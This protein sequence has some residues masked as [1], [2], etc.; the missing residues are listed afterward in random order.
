MTISGTAFFSSNSQDYILS[1]SA[2]G[3]QASLSDLAVTVIDSK[4]LSLSGVDLRGCSG[5]LS[6]VLQYAHQG[7]LPARP[8]ASIGEWLITCSWLVGLGFCPGCLPAARP[9]CETQWR[10]VFLY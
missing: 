4:T 2:T 8:I 9:D 7:P 6:A 1:L 3:C 5:Q 10:W